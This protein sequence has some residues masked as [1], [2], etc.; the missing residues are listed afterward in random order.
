MFFKA[1]VFNG[2]LCCILLLSCAAG[3]EKNVTRNGIPFKKLRQSANKESFTG[4]IDNDITVNG[5]HCRKGWIRFYKDWSLKSFVTVKD[6]ILSGNHIPSGT[7]IEFDREGSMKL[8]AFPE[9]TKIQG[10]LCKGTRGSPMGFHT[11]F[12]NNGALHYFFPIGK[13]R[14][15]G[16][17]CKGGFFHNV[18][19]YP[20]GRL[21]TCTLS[22]NTEIKGVLYKKG[23]ALEFDEESQLK[24]YK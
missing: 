13:I 15:D 22:E 23:T 19:L 1:C 3:W 21:K 5:N 9:N 16:I 7:W 24:R 10:Y 14:I 18:S 6:I 12:H 4:Y 2:L 11:S 8:C 17:P 20:D